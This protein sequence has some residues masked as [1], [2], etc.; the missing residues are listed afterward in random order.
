MQDA[1]PQQLFEQV[2]QVAADLEALK[3]RV[4]SPPTHYHNGFD[5][6]QISWVDIYQKRLHVVHTVQST[7]AATSTFYSTFLIVPAPALIIGFQEVHQTAGTD[8]S[9]VTLD[10]EKLTGTTAPGS[11]VSALSSTI[12]L[13]ATA[14]TVQTA[15][16]TSTNANRTL[17]AGD[18]LALKTSGTLTAVANVTTLTTLQLI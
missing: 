13:K 4:D 11:G 5:S 7:N 3:K 9:A 14:S 12:S 2:Q 17:A 15:T 1:N 18:R 6:N 16:I 8:A 10:L